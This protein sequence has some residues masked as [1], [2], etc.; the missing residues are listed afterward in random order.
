MMT[1]LIITVILLYLAGAYNQYQMFTFLGGGAE[2]KTFLWLVTIFWFLLTFFT[3]V[4]NT[5]YNIFYNN[6]DNGHF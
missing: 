5:W 4:M 2:N 1:F 6:K 3:C